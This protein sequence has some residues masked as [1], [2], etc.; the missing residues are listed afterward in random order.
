MA[1]NIARKVIQTFQSPAQTPADDESERLSPREK[2]VLELL[3][4]GQ[5]YKEIAEALQVSVPTVCTYIRRI[6]KNFTSAH[7]PKQWP[8]IG[9]RGKGPEVKPGGFAGRTINPPQA[10][11]SLPRH[12]APLPDGRSPGNLPHAGSFETH[13][14]VPHAKFRH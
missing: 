13:S 1:G 10:D 6:Y 11:R 8:A 9:V 12:P 14:A 4:Q 3:A 7:A 5:L 2:Q